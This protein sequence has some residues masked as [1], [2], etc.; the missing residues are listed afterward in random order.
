MV[1]QPTTLPRAS[2]HDGDLVEYTDVSSVRLPIRGMMCPQGRF[3]QLRTFIQNLM[4]YQT[5][6]G[7]F[8]ENLHSYRHENLIPHIIS[9]VCNS[10]RSAH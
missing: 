5:I 1:P 8:Q 6:R 4:F 2:R 7:H 9:E 3:G 10:Q